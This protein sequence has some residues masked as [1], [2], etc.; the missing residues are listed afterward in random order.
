MV[1]KYNIFPNNRSIR[2]KSAQMNKEMVMDVAARLFA[3]HSYAAVSLRDI[4][5]K[6]GAT[7]GLIYHYFP[8]KGA[9]LGEILL[10]T[11]QMFLEAVNPAWKTVRADKSE[12]LKKIIKSH[13]NFNYKR[14]YMIMLAFRTTDYIPPDMRRKLKIIRDSYTN[15]FSSLVKEVQAEGK[16]I[17]GDSDKIATSIVTLV[18]YLPYIYRNANARTRRELIQIIIES[19]IR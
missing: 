9:L 14:N 16:L 17:K 13:F 6:I 19:F 5:Q 2:H 10:W 3:E 18:N 1:K 7:Q 8:S 4:A 15:K 12:V 11:H